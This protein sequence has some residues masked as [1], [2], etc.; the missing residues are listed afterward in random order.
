VD[1]VDTFGHCAGY[2]Y[3]QCS[4]VYSNVYSNVCSGVSKIRELY[5]GSPYEQTLEACKTGN[6]TTVK[7]SR[8][9][10]DKC[11]ITAAEYGHTDIVK[12]L[13]ESENSL[14]SS[15][16]KESTRP[17]SLYVACVGHPNLQDFEDPKNQENVK[18]RVASVEHLLAIGV[19][20]PYC[21]LLRLCRDGNDQMFDLV[22]DHYTNDMDYHNLQTQTTLLYMACL[23]G[24]ISLVNK[25]I[26]R[27]ADINQ[28]SRPS[29]KTPL[30][31][32]VYGLTHST[33]TPENNKAVLDRLYELNV[34]VKPDIRGR[35]PSP[36][37]ELPPLSDYTVISR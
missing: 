21:L 7:S 10:D 35:L 29:G 3:Q 24:H 32:A 6:L 31:A 27:G 23:Y 8:C 37:W 28:S 33:S 5:V 30:H 26:A 17:N 13:L 1:N 4:N 16:F 25:L 34:E 19:K 18:N 36:T 20:V 14:F 2:V 11:L 15:K 12:Y 9:W 22:I